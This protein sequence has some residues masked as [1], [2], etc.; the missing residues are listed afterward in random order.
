MKHAVLQAYK[1]HGVCPISG[2][3][4]PEAWVCIA[5]SSLVRCM[6]YA[7]VGLECEDVVQSVGWGNRRNAR[8][9]SE[10]ANGDPPR[11]SKEGGNR[12]RESLLLRTYAG[13]QAERVPPLLLCRCP[14]HR[15]TFYRLP[16]IFSGHIQAWEVWCGQR[17]VPTDTM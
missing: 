4:V 17:V 9:N 3:L 13:L 10:L 12:V 11:D 14:S 2:A 5:G 7:D 1:Q 15:P 6:A 8:S 16:S